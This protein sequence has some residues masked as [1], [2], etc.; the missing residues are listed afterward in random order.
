MLVVRHEA[1]SLTISPRAAEQS[2]SFVPLP[3]ANVSVTFGLAVTEPDPDL[4]VTSPLE[5]TGL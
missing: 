3:S 4:I 5:S 1:E 2:T